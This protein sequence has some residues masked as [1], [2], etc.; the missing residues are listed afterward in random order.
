V[1]CFEHIF[2][3]PTPIARIILSRLTKEDADALRQ[4]SRDVRPA[5]NSNVS[6]VV[7]WSN[8][9]RCDTEL[10]VV[11]PQANT[12]RIRTDAWSWSHPTPELD[13][14]AL[15]EHILATSP[16]LVTNLQALDVQLGC[17][18]SDHM[19]DDIEASAAGF[20]SRCDRVRM[21]LCAMFIVRSVPAIPPYCV[22][23]CCI[24]ERVRPRHTH[25]VT[26]GLEEAW[27]LLG[28][29]A[30]RVSL[31]MR[32]VCVLPPRC[33]NLQELEVTW[34][35]K[36]DCSS[37]RQFRGMNSTADP[38]FHSVHFKGEGST[39]HEQ[40]ASMQR[41]LA[42]LCS[43]TVFMAPKS[44]PACSC[45]V[46]FEADRF[47]YE[48]D[49]SYLDAATRTPSLARLLVDPNFEMGYDETDYNTLLNI[50]QLQRLT[51]L[52]LS[53]YLPSDEYWALNDD[54]VAAI[55][56]LSGLRELDMHAVLLPHDAVSIDDMYLYWTEVV[57]PSSWSALSSL[58]RVHLSGAN[59]KEYK[60]LVSHLPRL[61]AVEHLGFGSYVRP[62]PSST[63][64]ELTRLTRLEG[65]CV[66][67]PDDDEDDDE[68][69]EAGSSSSSSRALEVPQQWKD[70][71]QH[72][73]LMAYSASSGDMLSQL[74]SL[75]FLQLQG[76]LGYPTLRR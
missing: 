68:E 23:L 60:V 59:F 13:I 65:A 36:E 42:A 61:V 44:W 47:G 21:L 41:Q 38:C 62:Q 55:A 70:G 10:A 7:C 39:A 71:L 58:T 37:S 16:A 72:L 26:S 29:A 50:S 33:R 30:C 63:L 35:D 56:Q 51:F 31:R 48:T 67:D 53:S 19:D 57:I 52:Q 27:D 12:L 74:T 66:A 14:C 2:S 4:V 40:R 69:E 32:V 11:F 64:F 25:R 43:S 20:L 45:L 76:Y 6:T 18:R 46:S 15:L 9:P 28:K 1:C 73:D 49:T 75:T 54:V 34:R 24:I 22:H 8:G 3:A 17:V 5:V